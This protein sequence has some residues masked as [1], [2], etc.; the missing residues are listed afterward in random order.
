MKEKATFCFFSALAFR[1]KMLGVWVFFFFGFSLG[2]SKCF[3][4][5]SVG[6]YQLSQLGRR[7]SFSVFFGRCGWTEESYEPPDLLV[8][9]P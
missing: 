9:S 8:F 1:L 3:L 2:Q 4:F 5:E 6:V 7:L